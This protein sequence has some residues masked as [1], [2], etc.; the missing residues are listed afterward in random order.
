MGKFE[1]E[2]YIPGTGTWTPEYDQWRLDNGCCNSPMAWALMKWRERREELRK[3]A[4]DRRPLLIR[5]LVPRL[6]V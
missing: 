1:G 4:P 3:T 6:K 5:L 2:K